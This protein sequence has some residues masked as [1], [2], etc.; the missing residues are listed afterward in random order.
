MN[1]ARSS[2]WAHYDLLITLEVGSATGWERTEVQIGPVG[3]AA[4]RD[5]IEHKALFQLGTPVW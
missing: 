4:G 3:S 5:A 2:F 1:G